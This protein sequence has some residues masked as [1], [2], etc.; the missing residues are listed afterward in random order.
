MGKGV[1]K[2]GR[3]QHPARRN[4]PPPLEE[5]NE[6]WNE[7]RGHDKSYIRRTYLTGG[8]L[9]PRRPEAAAEPG[10]DVCRTGVAASAASRRRAGPSQ[11]CH[12]GHATLRWQ[13]ARSTHR[14][15]AECAADREGRAQRAQARATRE[16]NRERRR[17]ERERRFGEGGGEGGEEATRDADEEGEDEAEAEEDRRPSKVCPEEPPAA[18]A[19]TAACELPERWGLPC[20]HWLWASAA[21]GTP[22]PLSLVHPRWHLE[23]PARETQGRWRMGWSPEALSS[24]GGDGGDGGSDGESEEDDGE[25]REEEADRR[26]GDP[27]REGVWLLLDYVIFALL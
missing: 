11:G 6:P 1:P 22:I 4:L 14:C 17:Q 12:G 23:A 25:R 26:H 24:G 3:L 8:G 13:E 2:P 7:V 20:R 19:C 21:T 10:P 15:G 5:K 9:G 16:E 18:P 27:F